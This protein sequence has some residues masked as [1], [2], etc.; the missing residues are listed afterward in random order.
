MTNHPSGTLAIFVRAEGVKEKCELCEV[1]HESAAMALIVGKPVPREMKY[2]TENCRQCQGSGE[3]T[4]TLEGWV[5]VVGWSSYSCDPDMP[6]DLELSCHNR[7]IRG[8]GDSF[9]DAKQ[10]LHN[11][12]T[13]ALQ[14]GT[15]P[16]EIRAQ[17]RVVEG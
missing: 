16:D 7:Q 1:H 17:L 3:R 14:D 12:I 11:Q 6:Y 9:E 5:E 2:D 15:C 13:Q 8:H 4:V 10:D